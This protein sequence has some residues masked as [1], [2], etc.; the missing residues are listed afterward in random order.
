VIALARMH[1]VQLVLGGILVIEEMASKGGQLSFAVLSEQAAEWAVSTRD[2][3][4][5]IVAD[6]ERH[7]MMQRELLCD[8]QASEADLRQLDRSIDEIIAEAR[9][10]RIL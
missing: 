1:P 3:M 4:R 2:L 7:R 10:G 5:E 8:G 6:G 9:E